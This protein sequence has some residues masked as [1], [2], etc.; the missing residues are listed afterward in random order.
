M[1]LSLE[2][3]S[4]R[5]EIQELISRYSHAIDTRSFDDAVALF[6]SDGTLDYT[7]TGG[8]AGD[9]KSVLDYIAGAMSPLKMS[10][11][12]VATSAITLAGDTATARSICHVSMEPQ[13]EDSPVF[14]SGLLYLD[15]FARAPEGWRFSD[16]RVAEPW[17][18]RPAG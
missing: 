18:S 5:L 1:T 16:R 10:Q 8:P 15:T 4:D 17:F 12:Q 9:R 2:Q 11:H 13:G 14:F 6:T 3:I 7:A